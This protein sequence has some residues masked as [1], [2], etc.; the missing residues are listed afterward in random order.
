[1]KKRA[2][3][4]IIPI[5]LILASW[6]YW[7]TLDGT[8]PI[9]PDASSEKRPQQGTASP[10]A[11]SDLTAPRLAK[12]QTAT[13]PS[14]DSSPA[15]PP[16]PD[17]VLAKVD[18]IVI[19]RGDLDFFTQRRDD[20]TALDALIDRALLRLE[21]RQRGASI[22][23]TVID[24]RI[25]SIVTE[26][27]HGDAAAFENSLTTQGYTVDLVRRAEREKIEVQAMRQLLLRE[28]EAVNGTAQPREDVIR[29]WIAQR[30][31]TA[32]LTFPRIQR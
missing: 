14:Q 18:D 21:F 17:D 15:I 20:Q 8:V 5:L 11:S 10:V 24:D 19:T 6:W 7:R 4:F 26:N 22:P 29:E 12:R 32:P 28:A 3:W 9:E 16:H 1:M 2:L 25:D 13:A 23:E 30:R 31:T 27:F